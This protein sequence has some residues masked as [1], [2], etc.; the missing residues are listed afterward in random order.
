MFIVHKVRINHYYHYNYLLNTKPA[1]QSQICCRGLC[2]PLMTNL[3]LLNANPPL[4]HWLSLR[5]T[6]ESALTFEIYSLNT[7]L[8]LGN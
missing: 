1:F 7:E 8:T 2:L 5:L 6:E 4:D 3:Q